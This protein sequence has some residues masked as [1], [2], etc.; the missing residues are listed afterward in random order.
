LS[1]VAADV[2]AT[3]RQ[4]VQAYEQV[5]NTL[6][7]LIAEIEQMRQDVQE[8]RAFVHSDYADA[9]TGRDVW[10]RAAQAHKET[11]ARLEQ[12]LKEFQ[13]R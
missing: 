11:A 10:R 7:T 13:P 1:Q 3:L 5:M 12:Q 9:L 8:L 2:Y 4:L 6:P